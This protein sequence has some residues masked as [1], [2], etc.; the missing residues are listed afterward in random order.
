[1]IDQ[2]IEM[3]LED[4]TLDSVRTIARVVHPPFK[5]WYRMGDGTLAPVVD[6]VPGVAEPW[7]EP[8]QNLPATYIQTA[9]IDVLRSSVVTKQ[10]S[11][12]GARVGGFLE[13][14]FHDIDTPAEL[15]QVR[16]K[17]ETVSRQTESSPAETSE[18]ALR[19]FCF[20]IDGII[21]TL[22]PENNYR[23][24]GPRKEVI[25]RINQ[26]YHAGHHIV[27]FTARGSATGI[28]W[29][30]LTISQLSAW[31]V[32]YH[33]LRFGKPTADYYIDDRMLSLTDLEQLIARSQEF[34]A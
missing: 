7:N 22:T 6:H 25:Q 1:M 8:R 19:T 21:A 34:V 15:Q 18:T 9:N 24:A 32:K 30:D 26:L 3:L 2:M 11:M 29:R 28:D 23:L 13:K 4:E 5:M 17:L 16:E 14:D 20:D 12:T 27:L 10:S 31:G 33:V